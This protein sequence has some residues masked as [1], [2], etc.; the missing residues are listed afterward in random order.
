MHSQS[1]GANGD[2]SSLCQAF[3]AAVRR[4]GMDALTLSI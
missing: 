1:Q 4:G 2:G 3:Q